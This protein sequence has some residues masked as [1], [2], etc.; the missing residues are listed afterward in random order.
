MRHTSPIL[1]ALL[2]ANIGIVDIVGLLQAKGESMSS[3]ICTVGKS[4]GKA[5]KKLGER[6][7]G[8]SEGERTAM[9]GR[10]LGWQRGIDGKGD[11]RLY[12]PTGGLCGE[13]KCNK[14]RGSSSIQECNTK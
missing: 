12:D 11:Q 4:A 9:F 13:T 6:G 2:V 3:K 8:R 10:S 7:W 1:G 14:D 5:R